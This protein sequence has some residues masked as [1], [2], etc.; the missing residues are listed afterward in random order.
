LGGGGRRIV[1]LRPA[2]LQQTLFQK[3][4]KRKKKVQKDLAII[5]IEATFKIT[6]YKKVENSNIRNDTLN[7]LN[8]KKLREAVFI[9]NKTYFKVG[10][11]RKDRE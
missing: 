4:Q 8:Y 9:S 1:I 11:I 6:E 7:S 10:S 5:S 2:G 3:N